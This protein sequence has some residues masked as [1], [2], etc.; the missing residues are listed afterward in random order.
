MRTT[1]AIHL[2]LVAVVAAAIPAVGIAPT[3]AHPHLHSSKGW[4]AISTPSGITIRGLACYDSPIPAF[5][6][7]MESGVG[8]ACF[9]YTTVYGS[10][11]GE[12]V[13]VH[14]TDQGLGA[15][16]WL[17][18]LD[19]DGD[20]LCLDNTPDLIQRCYTTAT[21]SS[22]GPS[23]DCTVFLDPAAS[24]TL[25]VLT[26]GPLSATGSNAQTAYDLFY[27]VENA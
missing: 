13:R 9:D 19:Y 10:D 14:A 1:Y 8:G 17:T 20:D 2:M 25:Y 11:A 16:E 6:G 7:D 4:G 12:T 15:P 23:G 5:D 18:C 24:P 22:I 21:D 27:W 3:D 26:I